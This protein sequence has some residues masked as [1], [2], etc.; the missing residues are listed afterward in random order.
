MMN[1]IATIIQEKG[2]WFWHKIDTKAVFEIKGFDRK[3]IVGRMDFVESI[4][5]RGAEGITLEEIC[6]N[7]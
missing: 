3:C 2:I 4:L 5:R 6:I 7:E 1:R